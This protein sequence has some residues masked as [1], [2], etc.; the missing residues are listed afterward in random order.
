MYLKGALRQNSWRQRKN[1]R[2]RSRPIDDPSSFTG[3]CVNMFGRVEVARVVRVI[4]LPTQRLVWVSC[5][6]LLQADARRC[7]K[8]GTYGCIKH[9][10]MTRYPA[11]HG[12]QDTETWLRAHERGTYRADVGS[13]NEGLIGQQHHHGLRV[14]IQCLQADLQRS[15]CVFFGRWIDDPSCH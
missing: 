12:N 14:A 5:N 15:G 9:Y 6:P 11:Y 2:R 10:R 13:I 4:H 7:N 3:K 8:I 1:S